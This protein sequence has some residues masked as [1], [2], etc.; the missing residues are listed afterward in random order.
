ME[1]ASRG[2]CQ[3]VDLL[4]D[5]HIFVRWLSDPSRLTREQSRVLES[6]MRR[7]EPVALSAITLFEVAFLVTEGKVKL[8]RD[9]NELM[10]SIAR[11]PAYRLLPL[12]P[13]I[14]VEA[15]ALR[16]LKDIGD[17]VVAATARVHGLRLV[18]S[19]RRIIDSNLVSTIE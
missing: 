12:S 1:S 14:A 9:L 5:T 8:H 2:R 15:A 17:R 10:E 13:A 19:D 6:A 4:V 18:T 16:P 11:D 3:I 7:R